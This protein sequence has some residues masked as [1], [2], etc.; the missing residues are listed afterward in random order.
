LSAIALRFSSELVRSIGTTFGPALLGVVSG[1]AD[2]EAI[3]RREGYDY[4][5]RLAKF[6]DESAA[7]GARRSIPERLTQHDIAAR[8]GC[9]REMV[10]RILRDLAAGGYISIDSKQITLIK[11]LPPNW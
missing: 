5:Q 6:I 4:Y 1:A 10:S 8:I 11:K 9:S 7:R 2:L 3:D